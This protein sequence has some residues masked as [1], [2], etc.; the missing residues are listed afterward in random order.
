MKAKKGE[1]K[2]ILVDAPE[3]RSH[4]ERLRPAAGYGY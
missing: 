1:A 4:E 3:F 2:S